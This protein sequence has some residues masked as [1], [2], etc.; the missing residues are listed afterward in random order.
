MKKNLTERAK[1]AETCR[2]DSISP[3]WAKTAHGS[4]ARTQQRTRHTTKASAQHRAAPSN[5]S[6]VRIQ[7]SI[8]S[9]HRG[10]C[11]VVSRK[12]TQ[13]HRSR[14][15]ESEPRSM[16]CRVLCVCVCM[17][18]SAIELCKYVANNLTTAVAASVGRHQHYYYII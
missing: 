8:E 1:F 15:T 7:F 12:Q 6:R 4:H 11:V 10:M 16:P 5:A 13:I 17:S 2:N 18:A 9:K 14:D 3:V